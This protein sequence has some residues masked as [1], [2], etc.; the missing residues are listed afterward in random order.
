M[1]AMDAWT[2]F[3]SL[4]ADGDHLISFEEAFGLQNAPC[5][6]LGLESLIGTPGT[7]TISPK[8]S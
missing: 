5:R 3:D 7:I 1:N 2:L 8:G 4:D 6:V